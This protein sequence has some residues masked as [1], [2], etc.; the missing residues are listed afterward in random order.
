MANGFSPCYPFNFILL[1]EH[2]PQTAKIYRSR[3]EDGLVLAVICICA[4]L[5]RLEVGGGRN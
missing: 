1:T 2:F 4:L 5:A 3:V